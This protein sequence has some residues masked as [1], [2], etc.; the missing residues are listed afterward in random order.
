MNRN[1]ENTTMPRRTRPRCTGLRTADRRATARRPTGDGAIGGTAGPY[2]LGSTA[3]FSATPAAGNLFI[4]WT[5]DGT[6]VGFNPTLALPMTKNRAVVAAFAPS[7]VFCDVTPQTPGYTAIVNLAARGVIKGQAGC[8]NPSE[9]LLRAQLAAML[10]RAFGWDAEDHGN[11]FPDQGAV[12]ADLW[13]NVGTLNYYNVAHGYQDGTYQPTGMVLHAQAIS[14]A[15]RALVTKGYWQ[16]Q[17]DA[18]ANYPDVPATSGHRQDLATYVH[19]A[20][21]VPGTASA[22]APW[23]G[24]GGWDQPASRSY[25]SVNHIP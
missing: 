24:P 2:P 7:P 20:G 14:F 12:D 9:P 19:F 22:T 11:P 6:F 4:G 15:T 8:F 18:P 25:F 13:R 16:P 3:T 17:A 10:A 21:A 23:D 5:V 1:K